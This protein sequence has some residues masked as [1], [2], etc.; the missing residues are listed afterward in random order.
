MTRLAAAEAW[1]NSEVAA[2]AGAAATEMRR[3][4]R[5]E[6]AAEAK[7][8]R[9][10]GAAE[11]R[12]MRTEGAV[13][14][15]TMRT[16]GA[17]EARYVEE[18]RRQLEEGA[19]KSA[20]ARQAAEA[21]TGALLGYRRLV[22]ERDEQRRELE[23][24]HK[25]ERH[26]AAAEAVEAAVRLAAAEAER[27]GLL[28]KLAAAH[29]TAREKAAEAHTARAEVLA[30]RAERHAVDE[31]R[32]KVE[33]ARAALETAEVAAARAGAQRGYAA[34][35]VEAAQMQ[36]SGETGELERQRGAVAAERK[37]LAAQAERT[38]AEEARRHAEVALEAEALKRREASVARREAV[39]RLQGESGKRREEQGRREHG[40]LEAAMLGEAVGVST[41]QRELAAAEPHHATAAELHAA[42]DECARVHS[43]N[44]LLSGAAEQ[45]QALCAAF[46]QQLRQSTGERRELQARA[47]TPTP[48]LSSA[49]H[50]LHLDPSVVVAPTRN[51][52]RRGRC[53]SRCSLPS[54]A[55]RSS[56][57]ARRCRRRRSPIARRR[58]DTRSHTAAS[59]SGHGSSRS[60]RPRW[61]SPPTRSGRRPRP[62]RWHRS[63]RPPS[64]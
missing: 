20:E 47:P 38:A 1:Q 17:M 2:M 16:E 41:L 43:A 46:E 3:P 53:A 61:H 7:R 37:K 10:E 39:L 11:V 58:T 59:G 52:L 6:G 44:A 33:A 60:C 42:A 48:L 62:R 35:E 54:C 57:R 23:E 24:R 15:R 14:A 49:P 29:A 12:T 8:M 64:P 34:A 28:G 18:L 45:A 31:E 22:G 19:L 21:Q 9:T 30:L 36:L 40:E 27:D 26:E 63:S 55:P 50:P 13:E 56:P 4:M 5:T 25:V 51:Q 32:A